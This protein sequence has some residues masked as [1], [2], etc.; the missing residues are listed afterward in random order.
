[1]LV[2]IRNASREPAR[3]RDLQEVRDPPG[4]E[5]AHQQRHAIRQAEPGEQAVRQLPEGRRP[6]Q[7]PEH[8]GDLGRDQKDEEQVD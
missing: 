7:V 2:H 4:R 5:G 1:M 3:G 8:R 6:A